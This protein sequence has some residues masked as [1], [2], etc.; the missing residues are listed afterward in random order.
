[1]LASGDVLVVGS[2]ILS[3]W[4]PL[5]IPPK[6]QPPPSSTTFPFPQRLGVLLVVAHGIVTHSCRPGWPRR[7]GYC[8]SA[9]VPNQ[10]H[11][12]G[13]RLTRPLCGPTTA[14]VVRNTTAS[15]FLYAAFWHVRVANAANASNKSPPVSWPPPPARSSRWNASAR[16]CKSSSRPRPRGPSSSPPQPESNAA[17]AS[18]AA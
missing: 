18:L 7:T 13:L 16:E 17:T 10:K 2:F 3:P 14:V 8:S 6:I 9:V 5:S 4:T 15:R 12:A 1:M 11:G